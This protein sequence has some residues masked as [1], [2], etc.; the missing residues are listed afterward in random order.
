M[1]HLNIDTT[2]DW[3]TYIQPLASKGYKLISPAVTNAG[4]P[5]GI[6]WYLFSMSILVHH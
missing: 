4:A 6:A 5:G 1:M 3:K 2:I